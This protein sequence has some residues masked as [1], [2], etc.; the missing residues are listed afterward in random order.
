MTEQVTTWKS[1]KYDSFGEAAKQMGPECGSP[2][3]RT[4]GDTV[5]TN[6][7][8]GWPQSHH[9]QDI[10]LGTSRG[11]SCS[12]PVSSGRSTDPLLGKTDRD[13]HLYPSLSLHMYLC[14][15]TTSSKHVYILE[16]SRMTTGSSIYFIPFSLQHW[17]N[18]T[19]TS[20]KQATTIYVGVLFVF[21]GFVV[22]VFILMTSPFKIYN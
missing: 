13:R 10:R 1:K 21:R 19:T 11:P 14:I 22:E 9:Q 16:S 15:Y 17:D 2:L 8:P 5:T 12:S 7:I 4:W 18:F 3:A 6:P 20:A